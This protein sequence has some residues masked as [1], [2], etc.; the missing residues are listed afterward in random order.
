MRG[1]MSDRRWLA[2]GSLVDPEKM[3]QRYERPF[4]EASESDS[5]WM[6]GEWSGSDR[7]PPT[8]RDRD[9]LLYGSYLHRLAGVTQVVTPPEDH[10]SF[11]S[12][13]THSFKVANLAREIA[14]Q[15]SSFAR[16][17]E[18]LADRIVAYGGLDVDACEAAGLAHDLG[19]PPFGHVAEKFLDEWLRSDGIR[20]GIRCPNGFEGNAQTFHIVTALEQKDAFA[21][22]AGPIRGRGG[23]GLT[24]VTLAATL[25]Y[26]WIRALGT[27]RFDSKFGAY[28]FD[29]DVR[30]MSRAW[31]VG[32]A[33]NREYVQT[34]EASVMDL[35]DDITYAAHDLQDFALNGLLPA[36]RIIDDLEQSAAFLDRN[37]S[38][39][40]PSDPTGVSATV[41]RE[42]AASDVDYMKELA[43]LST[44]ARDFCA[45]W[46]ELERY[47]T[48]IANARDYITQMRVAV[49]IVR[50][51]RGPAEAAARDQ[52]QAHLDVVADVRGVIAGIVGRLMGGIEG[53]KSGGDQFHA[54]L[55]LTSESWHLTQVL[56]R[57]T[58]SYVI[59]TPLIGI[60]QV[61]Q[62]SSLEALL[63]RL[64]SWCILGAG[65]REKR[66]LPTKL[67]SILAINENLIASA[68][69]RNG[70]LDF[71]ENALYRSIADYC[72]S[73]T[74]LE[75]HHLSQI[76]QGRELPRIVL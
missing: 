51:L 63:D 53:V 42:L 41:G 60:H 57:V 33:N 18:K 69:P 75:A 22:S 73:L 70:G 27:P 49:R 14:L 52:G 50:D 23:I 76:L 54:R 68:A 30:R 5:A 74:D 15:L 12:R 47:Y 26:P 20:S 66:Y 25:K 11:H 72:C 1:L 65:S 56:K 19:H 38:F 71:R 2:N 39:L 24:A 34:L 67:Q 28:H 55:E 64:E 9:R 37:Y 4:N 29:E 10:A 35:A 31:F 16:D 62:I 58:K 3:Q 59:E 32:K 40:E 46:W 13:M 21:P 8:S 7:R 36:T 6:K 44:G 17:D 48:H 43:Q 61:A 45:Y